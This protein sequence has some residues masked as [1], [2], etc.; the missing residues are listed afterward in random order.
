MFYVA[1]ICTWMCCIRV[2]WSVDPPLSRCGT[3]R[4]GTC[5]SVCIWSWRRQ[6]GLLCL[7]CDG[8][9]HKAWY[10]YFVLHLLYII[11]LCLLVCTRRVIVVTLWRV[12]HETQGIYMLFCILFTILFHASFTVVWEEDVNWCSPCR[13]LYHYKYD[14][15]KLITIRSFQ[16]T[17]L[18]YSVYMFCYNL[19]A[20]GAEGDSREEDVSWCSPRHMLYHYRFIQ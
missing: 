7:L 4:S 5:L 12:R 8:Q 3:C 6:V 14:R 17:G 20:R 11:M 9:T 1:F 18:V 15:Q 2:F 16:L 19:S 13:M 10:I